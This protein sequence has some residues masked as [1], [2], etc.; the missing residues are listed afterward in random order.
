MKVNK[1]RIILEVVILIGLLIYAFYNYMLPNYNKIFGSSDK[2]INTS[3][4]VDFIEYKIGDTDFGIV[5]DK[6][7]KIYHLIYFDKNSIVLYNKNIENNDIDVVN[8]Q[9]IRNLIENDLLKKDS[10]ITL[11]KYNDKYYNEV[12]KS[13]N[14]YLNKYHLN[15]NINKDN[16]KLINKAKTI[17]NENIDSDSYAL[18]VMDLY[19]KELVDNNKNNK[20]KKDLTKEEAK[21]YTNN[22]YKKI[23]KFMNTNNIDNLDKN[24]DKLNLT[25]VA[26]DKDNIYKATKNSYFYIKTRKVYAY[27]AIRDLNN[28]YSYCYNGSIDDYV[29]GE[30]K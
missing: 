1:Y 25:E 14:K 21:E 6:N 11:I 8:N 5:L 13:F 26:G 27:I 29:E 22:I 2:F 12:Y 10:N 4:Y 18:F 28:T 17:S 3:K 15:N 24:N 9:I 20:E 30:C 23:E 7:K 19:S 16:N